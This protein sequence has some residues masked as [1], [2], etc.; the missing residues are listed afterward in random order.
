ME[1]EAMLNAEDLGFDAEDLKEAGPDKPEPATSAGNDPKKPEDNSSHL[2][3][4][5]WIEIYNFVSS[6]RIEGY[7]SITISDKRAKPVVFKAAA[8]KL[9]YAN[10]K[11][12]NATGKL[13]SNEYTKVNKIGGGANRH[14]QIKIFVAKGAIALRQFDYT[15]EEV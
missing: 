12:I 6:N 10:E 13:N 14:L 3:R 7:G 5:A 1:N 15:Y 8:T 2:T 4:G 9:Y 11:L